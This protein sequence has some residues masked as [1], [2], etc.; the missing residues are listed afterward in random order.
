MEVPTQQQIL[1]RREEIEQELLDFF[2]ETNSDFGLE[3][4]RKIIYHEEGTDDLTKIIAMFDTGQGL[5]ELENI[6][7]TINDA[8]NYFPHKCLAGL[9]L[10]EKLLELQ[11]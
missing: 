9:C 1:K 8:W 4:I 11:H 7:E 3:D 5:L 6:I 2:G 10:M